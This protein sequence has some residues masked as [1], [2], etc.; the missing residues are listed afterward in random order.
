MG[1]LRAG[2]LGSTLLL[3]VG[4]AAAQTGH[5]HHHQQPAAAASAP[6]ADPTALPSLACA[7]SPTPAF[8]RDGR[9]WLAWYARGHVY[10]QS[11]DDHGASFGPAA[12]VNRIPEPVDDQGEDRVQ[13]ALGPQ[14]QIY[15]AWTRKLEQRMTGHVRFSRS[16]DGGRSFSEP[17]NVNDDPS[18]IAHRFPALQVND[19]NR[20]FIAWIDKRDLAAAKAAGRDYDGAA[21]YYATSEDGGKTWPNRKLT[22]HS[23]ECCRIAMTLDRRGL[24]L[25]V[26]RHVFPGHIRDHALI[27]FADPDTPLPIQRATD[28]AWHIRG[29]PH[30]GPA[31]ARSGNT[32]HLAWFT[33]ATNRKGLFYKRLDGSGTPVPFGQPGAERPAIAAAGD[34]VVLAWKALVDDRTRLYARLSHDGGRHWGQPRELASTDSSSDHPQLLQHQGRFHASWQTASEGYRLLPVSTGETAQ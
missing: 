21:V 8:A 26:Y 28:D 24:P 32:P 23:C 11:S 3:G 25:I 20:L 17:V 10:V 19:G 34:T 22:D 12:V 4:T 31:I 1:V 30:H 29:C 33:A 13:I 14:G 5:D 15:L 27:R 16:L 9:L 7:T 6:C 2:I 18:V